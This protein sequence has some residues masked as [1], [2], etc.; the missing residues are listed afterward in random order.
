MP[1]GVEAGSQQPVSRGGQ[2]GE[3]RPAGLRPA[4]PRPAP[5]RAAPRPHM[6]GPPRVGGGLGG[7]ASRP[8]LRYA[9]AAAATAAP[10]HFHS[11]LLSFRF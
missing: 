2:G 1:G 9:P 7:G 3:G 10:G 8:A 4:A 6:R 11:G 5:P